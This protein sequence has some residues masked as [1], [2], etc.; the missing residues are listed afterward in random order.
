[1]W[2]SIDASEPGE[3]R[4]G[5]IVLDAKSIEYPLYFWNFDA[6]SWGI[7]EGDCFVYVGV[8][9]ADIRQ[10]MSFSSESVV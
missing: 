7:G 8:S 9:A 3:E 6:Q 2:I 10:S 5:C 4:Q 1:M